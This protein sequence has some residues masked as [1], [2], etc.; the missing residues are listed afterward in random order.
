M[1]GG[2]VSMQAVGGRMA[3]A[4]ELGKKKAVA[5]ASNESRSVE[6]RWIKGGVTHRCGETGLKKVLVYLTMAG[7]AELE[8]RNICTSCGGEEGRS[9]A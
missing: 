4:P 1:N 7:G 9:Y 2:E 3:E 6:R 8:R 5:G